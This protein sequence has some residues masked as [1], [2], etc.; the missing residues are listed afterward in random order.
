MSSGKRRIHQE[1]LGGGPLFLRPAGACTLFRH[2]A[3]FFGGHRLQTSFAADPAAFAA[4]FGHNLGD[5]RRAGTFCLG[6]G[7][8]NDAASILNGIE[9]GLPSAL[10][11][12][13]RSHGEPHLV[14][15]KAISN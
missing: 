4:H 6:D 8:E 14:K 2:V 10:W 5:Q 3:P 11:H 9:I 13:S 1:I 7:F 15:L 12:G